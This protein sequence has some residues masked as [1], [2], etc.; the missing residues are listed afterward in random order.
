MIYIGAEQML[1]KKLLGNNFGVG[2]TSAMAGGAMMVGFMYMQAESNRMNKNFVK[3]LQNSQEIVQTDGNIMNMLASTSAVTATIGQ[4]NLADPNDRYIYL[5]GELPW[6]LTADQRRVYSLNAIMK[7]AGNVAYQRNANGLITTPGDTSGIGGT[8]SWTFIEDIWIDNYQQDGTNGPNEFGT[9]DI[10]I[11]YRKYLK[12]PGGATLA[13][14]PANKPFTRSIRRSRIGVTLQ[15]VTGPLGATDGSIQGMTQQ[16]LDCGTCRITD[17][18]TWTEFNGMGQC[19]STEVL[20]ITSLWN[21]PSSGQ[22]EHTY[23]CC[24]NVN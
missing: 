11:L 4:A 13:D 17:S 15:R 9:A 8:G 6:P 14:D 1:F 18:S 7:G 5:S 16:K 20:Q 21:N 10:A 24:C 22:L 23:G 12:P 3:G 19:L 2:L